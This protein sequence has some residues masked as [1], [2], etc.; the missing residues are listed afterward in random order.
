MDNNFTVDSHEE[1]ISPVVDDS[2]GNDV[3]PDQDVY[4]EERNTA[5][6]NTNA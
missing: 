2:F 6:T 4:Y 1:L 5:A 3:T